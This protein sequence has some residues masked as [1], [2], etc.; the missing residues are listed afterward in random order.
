MLKF[1]VDT[2]LPPVLSDFLTGEGFDA[3]HTT[4][5]PNGHLLQDNEIIEIGIKENR[6]IITKD[7]DFFDRFIIKGFPPKILLLQLG[8]IRNKDLIAVIYLNLESVI[9]LF[10]ENDMIIINRNS[11]SGYK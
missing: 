2:Q 5:Y 4:F 11:I 6:I 3:I 9:E 8:N 7:K 10:D 1:I